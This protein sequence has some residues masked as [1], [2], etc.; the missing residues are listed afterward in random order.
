MH[1]RCHV[2]QQPGAPPFLILNFLRVSQTLDRVHPRSENP[3]IRHCQ[4]SHRRDDDA[5][6]QEQVWRQIDA[7]CEISEPSI[8][9]EESGRGGN[10]H[11]GQNQPAEIFR[12]DPKTHPGEAPSTFRMPI[13][14]VRRSTASPA[15]P[16]SPRQAI[17][18]AKA[19]AICSI[20][21][22]LRSCRYWAS[23]HSERKRQEGRGRSHTG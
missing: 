10:E 8:P 16:N 7:I 1:R 11:R 15:R 6:Q 21:P 12:E 5:R 2:W 23:T 17:S 22:S 3:L 19:E 13:S 9:Y 20:S 4:K 18:T 14:L